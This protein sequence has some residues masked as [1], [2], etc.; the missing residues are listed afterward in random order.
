MASKVNYGLT[1]KLFRNMAFDFAVKEKLNI[2]NSW[3]E[4]SLA[5]TDW[6][7]GFTHRN[8][9]ISLRTP[10]QLSMARAK[11]FNKEAVDSFYAQLG[12]LYQEKNYTRDR[13]WNMDETG[14][15]T[16]PTKVLKILAEKG[17]KR[18][19]QMSSEER[20]TNVTCALAVNAAGTVLPPFFLYAKIN[21]QD[22]FLDGCDKRIVGYANGSGY[23]Q[24]AEFVKFMKHFIMHSHA[25][26][27]T[28]SLLL[29]DNHTSHLCVEAIDLA[30]K[31]GITIFSFPPHCTHKLQPLDNGVIRPVKARYVDKHDEWMKM[32]IGKKFGIHHVARIVEKCVDEAATPAIIKSAFARTGVY[33]LNKNTFTDD[34]FLAAKLIAEAEARAG[35]GE[36][37]D[38]EEE[39]LILV[40]DEDMHVGS[41]EEVATSSGTSSMIANLNE[42]GPL[43]LGKL[44][45]KSNRGPKPMRSSVLTSS[46]VRNALQEAAEKRLA[47]KRKKED[48]SNKPPAKKRANATSASKKATQANTA[49]TSKKMVSKKTP[50]DAAPAKKSPAKK[51]A[52]KKAPGKKAKDKAAKKKDTSS[53]EEEAEFCLECNAY[54]T[55][56]LTRFNSIECNTCERIFHLA[57]VHLTGGYFTCR[58]CDSD[59]DISP[60]EQ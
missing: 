47:N 31:N 29:L 39:R 20:G 24:Q 17:T 1:V 43:K 60:K 42:S 23:M 46:P 12:D 19:S 21:M 51:S 53:S 58:N 33:E 10:E 13:I 36:P 27:K 45:K 52:G 55:E 56:P 34:D 41:N 3:K 2:P 35:G 50:A 37:A 11:G 26:I 22:R 18:V 57:C 40:L 5:G 4:K 16:V 44:Q 8:P 38:T 25:D 28:P 49:T 7:Y 6:Y 32:N 59:L 30:I 14:F 9:R 48:A 54:F 15:P